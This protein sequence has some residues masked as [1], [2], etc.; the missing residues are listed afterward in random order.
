MFGHPAAFVNGNM[1][2][3]LVKEK[4]ILRLDESDSEM[5]SL[6]P[7]RSHSLQCLDGG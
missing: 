2:A 1:F 6:F 7:G 3:G 5:F 4:M